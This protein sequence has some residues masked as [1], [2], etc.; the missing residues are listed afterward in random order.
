M[1]VWVKKYSFCPWSCSF[2]IATSQ[3][4]LLLCFLC[5]LI[6]SDCLIP[7]CSASSY[8]ASVLDSSFGSAEPQGRFFSCAVGVLHTHTYMH[9]YTHAGLIDFSSI[10]CPKVFAFVFLLGGQ[11]CPSFALSHMGVYENLR[12][13]RDRRKR[14]QRRQ[15]GKCNQYRGRGV[16]KTVLVVR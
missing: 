11:N 14:G 6:F 16:S 3:T 4:S 2:F 7:P 15:L 9:I 10:M 13:G 5:L 1:W 8:H 12:K